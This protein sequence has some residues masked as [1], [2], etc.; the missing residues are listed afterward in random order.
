MDLFI[1]CICLC[2]AVM[3]VLVLA[4]LW[5]PVGKGLAFLAFLYLMFSCFC[6][7]P[8]GVL[9]QLWYLIVSISDLC[10]LPY[11]EQKTVSAI[12]FPMWKWI[13]LDLPPH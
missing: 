2:H 5:S 11:L 1:I 4:V 8:F 10:S 9:G 7:F 12:Q 6:Y 13:V 3:P